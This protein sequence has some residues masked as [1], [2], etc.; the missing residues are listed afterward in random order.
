MYIASAQMWDSFIVS[1][2]RAIVE[3]APGVI[4]VNIDKI[5]KIFSYNRE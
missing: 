2:F 3:R 5:T 1:E 4:K